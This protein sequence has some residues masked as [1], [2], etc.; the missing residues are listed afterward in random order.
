M[1]QRKSNFR[2]PRCAF[3]GY[4]WC[5]V[6]C[7]GPGAPVNEIDAC[8]MRH[9]L[10]LHRGI[11]PCQCDHTFMECLRPKMRGHSRES[12]HASLMYHAFKLKNTFR[13]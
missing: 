8:C 5:G 6:R 1:L 3:S 12:R 9:D 7:S 2:K 4:R 10:C 13:C 11:H